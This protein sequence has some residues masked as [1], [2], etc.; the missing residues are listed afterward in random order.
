METGFIQKPNMNDIFKEAFN[1]QTINQ[2]DNERAILKMKRYNPPN[3]LFQHFSVEE[4]VKN[5][6]DNRMRNGQI[7]D[8]LKSV[9]NKEIVKIEGK[10]IRFFQGVV[11]RENCK[12]SPLR[13]LIEKLFASGQ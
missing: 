6:E 10:V 8:T 4:K 13:K 12:V 11:Y 9:D 1:N 2:D 3:V 5:L 7:I